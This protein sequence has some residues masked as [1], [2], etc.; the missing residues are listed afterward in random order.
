MPFTV[1]SL[2][3]QGRI[4]LHEGSDKGCA[5][6]G[7]GIFQFKDNEWLH[8]RFSAEGGGSCGQTE[9]DL[10]KARETITA[11]CSRKKTLAEIVLSLTEESWSVRVESGNISANLDNMSTL[12][13]RMKENV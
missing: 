11:P 3:L 7:D 6:V 5:C 13:Q 1:G 4:G 2:L 10:K 8:R 9:N 12:V